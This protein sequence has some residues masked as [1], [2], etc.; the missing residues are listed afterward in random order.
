MKNITIQISDV[1]ILLTLIFQAK[2]KLVAT[3]KKSYAN[4]TNLKLK[5]KII[6]QTSDVGLPVTC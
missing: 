3:L 4:K 5:V 1:I 6:E 2:K